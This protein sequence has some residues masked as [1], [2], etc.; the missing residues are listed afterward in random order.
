MKR[1][2][3]FYTY[4]LLCILP[5]AGM[6]QTVNFLKLVDD[7]STTSGG[8]PVSINV[9]INDIN[10]YPDTI[11]IQKIETYNP[12]L[13]FC[14]KTDSVLVYCPYHNH[15]SGIDS[16]KYYV[17][18]K[19]E[20]DSAYLYILIK[21][22]HAYDSLT[23]NNINAGVNA[24]GLLFNRMGYAEYKNSTNWD[25]LYIRSHFEVPKGSGK[26]TIFSSLLWIGGIYND[27]V[28]MAAEFSRFRGFDFWSG[29]VSDIYDLSYLHKWNRVWQ[30]SLDTIE[31]HL[32]HYN[33]N[34]YIVPE[35]ILTWP[36]NGNVQ[37]GQEE[38]L[39]PFFD[40]NNNDFYEPVLGDAPLIRGDEAIF[41]IYND[42]KYIH[43]DSEGR[44]MQLEF[45]AMV[46]GFNDIDSVL[47]NTV[48]VHYDIYNRSN[49]DYD[50]TFLGI[51]TDIDIGYNWDDYVGCDVE[52]GYYYGYNG[53]P[54]D[55][56]GGPGTYG[57]KPPAQSINILGGPH[58]D[59]D[60]LDNFDGGCDMSINGMNFGDGIVDNERMGM[61][62]FLCF[63]S[64]GIWHKDNKKYKMNY[65]NY[66]KG[67]LMDGT[68]ML[69]GGNGDTATGGVGPECKFMYPWDSDSCNWGTDGQ[70]PNGGYT[71]NGFY[72]NESSIGNQPH[73]RHVLGMMG[74]FTFIS[75]EKQELD[76]A[77]VFA[78]DYQSNNP[79]ASLNKLKD[80]NLLLKAMTGNNHIL[81]LPE[82]NVGIQEN[83]ITKKTLQIY[84]NPATDIIVLVAEI[85]SQVQAV[86][87]SIQGSTVL[88]CNLNSGLNHNINI[89]KLAKGMY[90]ITIYTRNEFYVG[91]FVK[92]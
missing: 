85:E 8:V 12:I 23:I 84:P 71:Q 27:T 42:D 92:Y 2:L 79:L 60:G 89:S 34:G 30:L 52:G 18:A 70:I 32:L 82:Y 64:S 21:N 25:D 80:Y 29:P 16:V 22:S 17:E 4:T 61:T 9:L 41:F 11:I 75:G 50:S 37:Y 49:R 7:Y 31:Y 81:E 36:G 87:K 24:C 38:K 67:I 63:I 35:N 15:P 43:A 86:I 5:F 90:I 53:Y 33:D 14:E 6:S 40:Q 10:L 51:Y 44:K 77:Y 62:G 72:W 13:G 48:F 83:Q 66:L 76:I 78:R 1:I 47:N 88:E 55:G 28:Y 56:D 73:E 65:Y 19:T 57:A 46:Y 3:I 45:H 54:V 74:P 59:P 20:I 26:N 91:K 58:I 69:Y 68:H 39:A